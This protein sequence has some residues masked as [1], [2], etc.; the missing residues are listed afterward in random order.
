MGEIRCFFIGDYEANRNASSYLPTS[1]TLR[2]LYIQNGY[3]QHNGGAFYLYG[4]RQV[5]HLFECVIHNNYAGFTGGESHGVHVRHRRR[6]GHVQTAVTAAMV[7]SRCNQQRRL[8]LVE[9][10]LL[11][12]VDDPS[13]PC[14]RL[15]A[16][17]RRVGVPHG[18][19]FLRQ[20]IW[21]RGRRCVLDPRWDLQHLGLHREA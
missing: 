1:L 9:C 21:G 17:L 14:R 18:L 7:S 13:L 8:G 15:W 11:V 3:D 4:E 6:R 10:R 12:C 5:V 19:H 20:H 2:D 16:P